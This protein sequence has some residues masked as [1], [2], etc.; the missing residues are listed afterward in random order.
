MTE[1]PWNRSRVTGRP[2]AT[3]GS[4]QVNRRDTGTGKSGGMLRAM[5]GLK[6]VVELAVAKANEE[7][8]LLEELEASAADEAAGDLV[9]FDAVIA[10]LSSKP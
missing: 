7:A 10:R 3:V 1:E 6:P 2:S 8:E 5:E 9:D 4:I